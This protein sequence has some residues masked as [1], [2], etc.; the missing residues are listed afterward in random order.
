VIDVGDVVV[1]VVVVV[2]WTVH[3]N[4]I[5]PAFPPLC[6]MRLS[7]LVAIRIA[8]GEKRCGSERND[9]DLRCRD[10][11]TPESGRAERKETISGWAFCILPLHD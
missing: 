2:S 9:G 11:K 1:D 7:R 5:F 3:S 4:Q 6:Y 8:L 10:A